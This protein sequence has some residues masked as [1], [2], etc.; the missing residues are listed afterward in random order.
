MNHNTPLTIESTPPITPEQQTRSRWPNIFNEARTN[1]GTWRM[2]NQPMTGNSAQQIASDIRR[3]AHRNPNKSRF[4]HQL[5]NEHWE[6]IHGRDD[7]DP[8]PNHFYIW[9]RYIGPT[10]TT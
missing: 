9:L 6:A 7:N 10:E 1:P 3:A 8:N 5:A 4:G 2:V